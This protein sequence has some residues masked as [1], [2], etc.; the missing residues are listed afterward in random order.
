MISNIRYTSMPR[1]SLSDPDLDAIQR[2]CE[3]MNRATEKVGRE[4]DAMNFGNRISQAVRARQHPRIF[5]TASDESNSF[6]KRL[7]K[8]VE[9][10]SGKKQHKDRA[11]R[12]R[13]RYPQPR[14]RTKGE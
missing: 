9:K 12:E 14:K 2:A 6:G 7:K 11:E 5:A 10:K 1:S 13:S 8:A 4:R 3:R